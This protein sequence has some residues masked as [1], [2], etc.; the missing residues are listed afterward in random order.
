MY[1]TKTEKLTQSY[2]INIITSEAKNLYNNLRTYIKYGCLILS[3]L[4]SPVSGTVGENLKPVVI[5]AVQLVNVVV[6]V[7]CK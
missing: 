6:I 5:T 4:S 7:K 2:S 1:L 3:A